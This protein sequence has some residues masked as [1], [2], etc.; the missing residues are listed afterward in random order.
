MSNLVQQQSCAV[1]VLGTYGSGSSAVAGVLYRL[2]VMMGAKLV[3][4]SKANPKGHFEDVHFRELLYSYRKDRSFI[5]KLH[6]FIE[7]RFQNFR[8][9]GVKEPAII[10]AIMDLAPMLENYNYKV[11]MTDR[12][13]MACARSYQ[14]KWPDSEIETIHAHIVNILAE[15]QRFIDSYK[16]EIL[17]VDFNALTEQPESNVQDIIRFVFG[18]RPNIMEHRPWPSNEQVQE[19]INSI[20]SDMNHR[21][22]SAEVSD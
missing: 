16:P 19:A 18:E 7:S 13:P 9:W 5:I 14:K 20:D 22:E 10:E 15:R 6:A 2:G 1:I 17:R 8:L 21:W 4:A 3:P 11:I 12:D